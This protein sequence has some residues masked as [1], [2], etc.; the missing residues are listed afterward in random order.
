MGAG[1]RE[2]LGCPGTVGDWTVGLAGTKGVWKSGW[3][4]KPPL[5]ALGAVEEAEG[6]LALRRDIWGRTNASETRARWCSG[7]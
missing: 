5:A 4:P 1:S 6:W 2:R 3:S 7:F